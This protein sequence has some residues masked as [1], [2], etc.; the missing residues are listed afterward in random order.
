MSS[1]VSVSTLDVASSRISTAR[2]ERERARE[3]QQLLL[4]DRQRGAAL[5]DRRLEAAERV[6]EPVGVHRRQHTPHLGVADVAALPSRTLPAIVPENR[7]TSCSTSPKRR[8]EPIERQLAD[9]DAVHA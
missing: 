9:V 1:S 3:R 7:C 6:D 8:A 4:P 5:D 2:V